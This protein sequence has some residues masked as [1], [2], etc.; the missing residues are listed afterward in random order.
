V[1]LVLLGAVDAGMVGRIGIP[2]A[3]VSSSP[4]PSRRSGRSRCSG[5]GKKWSVSQF[6]SATS[7]AA[8]MVNAAHH[9]LTLNKRGCYLPRTSSIS[10]PF[11]GEIPPFASHSHTLRCLLPLQYL[12]HHRKIAVATLLCLLL[13]SFHL[14]LFCRRLLHPAALL[15]GAPVG[16]INQSLWLVA[17][18]CL[19]CYLVS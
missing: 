4:S 14:S 18:C 2:S 7:N 10:V 6:R 15:I 12:N 5:G 1:H 11:I 17:L 9:L 13:E 3:G 8:E 19:L 16:S